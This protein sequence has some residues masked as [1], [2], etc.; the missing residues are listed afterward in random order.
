MPSRAIITSCSDKF[1]PS[2]INL[3]SS[4]KAN[5]P[6]HPPIYV[7]DLGLFYT[8]RRELEL[9]EGVTV[10]PVPPFCPH[11]RACYAWKTYIL[12]H[13][14]ADLNFYIDAG[15]QILKPLDEDFDIIA[16]EGMLLVDTGCPFEDLVPK[17]YRSI[18]DMDQ[19]LDKETTFSAGIIGFTNTPEIMQVFKKSYEAAIVGLTL[20]FSANNL[21]RNKGKDKN[22][23]TR[24][25][26]YFRHDQTVINLFFKKYLSKN[27]IPFQSHD[28]YNHLQTRDNPKQRIWQL[29]LT[30]KKL[31]YTQI[32]NLHPKKKIL[33]R[34][35]RLVISLMLLM[36]NLNRQLKTLFTR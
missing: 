18:F 15:C 14:F 1:F 35:N 12:A 36:K 19:S 25:S 29:R 6:N 16:K 27:K 30:Y 32:Q 21:W 17:E 28:N 33:F 24:S 22:I 31:E 10:L 7:Y 20:G 23:F 3:L 2:V 9:I 26:N 8:F 5:Y 13:P 34:F 11:W 4:L